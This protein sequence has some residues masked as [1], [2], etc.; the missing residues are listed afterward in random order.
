MSLIADSRVTAPLSSSELHLDESF[1][2]RTD[3]LAKQTRAGKLLKDAGSEGLLLLEPENLAWFSSGAT[4]RGV[5]DPV[6]QPG[7]FITPEQRWLLCSNADTQRLFDEELDGLGFQ[8]KEWPWHWGREQLVND[9]LQGRK[10]ACDRELA[11]CQLVRDELRQLR[12]SLT[13]YEQACLRALGQIVS[14]AV[15]ATCRTMNQNETEREVAGQVAHRLIHRGVF[16]VHL[17]VA[18]DGRSSVYRQFGFTAMR[19]ENY[20][21]VTAVGRKYGLYVMCSRTVSFGAP[22][23][24]LQ[25]ANDAAARVAA[26]YTAASWPDAIPSHIL[27]SG[28]RVYQLTGFEHDW[29]LA[30]QGHVTGRALVEVPITPD[31]EDLFHPGCAIIW[32][33]SAGPALCADTYLVTDGGPQPMTPTEAWPLKKIRVMGAEFFLPDLL[34]R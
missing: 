2:R 22:S 11:G 16:P 13:A 15:E 19:V 31:S 30:P 4:S 14:H 23:A 25:K 17:G 21:V 27:A 3:V 8:L 20:A 7:L 6:E 28:Q 9:L 18:A 5:F 1:D 10:V 33:A 12:R 24:D 32:R 34:T 26:T 29:L